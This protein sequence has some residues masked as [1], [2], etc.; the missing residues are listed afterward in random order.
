MGEILTRAALWPT[1][2]TPA[3]AVVIVAVIVIVAAVVAPGLPRTDLSRR[4]P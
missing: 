3:A 2:R 4:G 1:L